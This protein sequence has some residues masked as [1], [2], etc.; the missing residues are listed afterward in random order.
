M[1]ECLVF[2]NLLKLSVK[3]AAVHFALLYA[4]LGVMFRGWGKGSFS[5]KVSNS[6]QI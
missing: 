4:A 5:V 1:K 3:N 2:L 6:G